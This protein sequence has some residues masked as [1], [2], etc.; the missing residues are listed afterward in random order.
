KAS[1]APSIPVDRLRMLIGLARTNPRMLGLAGITDPGTLLVEIE[2]Y[3]K[4]ADIKDLTEEAKRAKET[5][6]WRRW[7]RVYRARLQR[8]VEDVESDSEAD[9]VRAER[10]RVMN[11]NNPKYILR[12][13]IAQTAIEKAEKGDFSEAQKVLR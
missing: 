1:V 6:L 8:E 7:L 9:A 3:N 5:R 12:N 4:M 11:R 10:V 13:Y 2:K